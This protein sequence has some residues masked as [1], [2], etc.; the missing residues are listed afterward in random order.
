[1]A[2]SMP[3]IGLSGI[4]TLVK[5]ELALVVNFS[6]VKGFCSSFIYDHL[7]FDICIA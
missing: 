7:K 6:I 1:M 5:L 4:C 2:S 3:D